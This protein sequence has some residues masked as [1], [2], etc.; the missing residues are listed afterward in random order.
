MRTQSHIVDTKAIKKVLNSFPDHWVVR[1]LT[2]RDYG[3]DLLVEIFQHVGANKHGKVYESSGCVCHL[4]VKGT[5]T[6]LRLSP[7]GTIGFSIPRKSLLYVERFAVPFFLLRVGV[8]EENS[9]CYFVWLQRY[10]KDVLDDCEPDWRMSNQ[11]TI[12]IQIP[13]DNILPESQSKFERIASTIKYTQELLEF[14]ETFTTI[15]QHLSSI[16][17]GRME[18]GYDYAY[19][20]NQINRLSRLRTLL[21]MNVCCIGQENVS[22]LLNL[23][24]DVKNGVEDKTC[25]DDYPDKYNFE[26]LHKSVD[27]VDFVE[28]LSAENEGETLY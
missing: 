9:S 15:S 19:I 14:R 27:S 7:S 11:E 24:V 4:Q 2:E 28:K 17:L 16:A 25:L 23:V 8:S 10:I 18:S 20:L 21:S 22:N 3:T 1:D 13:K 26:L 12:S 6:P 5:S